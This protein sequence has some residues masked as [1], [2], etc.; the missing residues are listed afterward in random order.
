MIAVPEPVARAPLG[1]GRGSVVAANES[2]RD[3]AVVRADA[4]ADAVSEQPQPRRTRTRERNVLPP[5]T[6]EVEQG[7][8]AAIGRIVQTA[9][10][11]EIFEVGARKASEEDVV[12]LAAAPGDAGRE[13]RVDSFVHVRAKRPEALLLRAVV[14]IQVACDRTPEDASAVADGGDLGGHGHEAGRRVDVEIAV[15]IEVGKSP[16]EAEVR[17]LYLD[18]RVVQA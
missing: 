2:H 16:T 9:D 10:A 18:A 5:V 17:S 7:K 3:K 14:G 11:R 6:V 15:V 13:G 1:R 4:V 12:A 8:G